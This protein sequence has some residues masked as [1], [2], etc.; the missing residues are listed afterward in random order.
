MAPLRW[1]LSDPQKAG[2]GGVAFTSDPIL[3]FREGVEGW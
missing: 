2:K 1:Q 3:R